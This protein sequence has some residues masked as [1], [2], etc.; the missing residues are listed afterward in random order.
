VNGNARDHCN[1]EADNEQRARTMGR[2][3]ARDRDYCGKMV[4]SNDWVGKTGQQAVHERLRHPAAHDVM[5][6][7][8]IDR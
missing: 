4:E 8:W 2:S 3:Q 1:H 6:E 5:G 7:R